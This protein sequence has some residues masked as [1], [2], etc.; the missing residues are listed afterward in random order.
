MN[1][2]NKNLNK[3][4]IDIDLTMSYIIIFTGHLL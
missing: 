2:W 1:I 3:N 4:K